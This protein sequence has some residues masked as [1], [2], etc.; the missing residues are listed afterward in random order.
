VEVGHREQCAAR[1]PRRDSWHPPSCCAE[2]VGWGELRLASAFF[3]AH[4]T[5]KHP[6][7]LK[8][9][10]PIR[11]R[12]LSPMYAVFWGVARDALLFALRRSRRYNPRHGVKYWQKELREA[13]AELDA[14]TTLTAVRAAA[15]RLQRAKAELKALE[16]ETKEQAKRRATRGE[17]G[18]SIPC[19][20]P[21]K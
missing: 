15:K 3:R 5:V 19:K 9:E 20:P 1:S 2:A 8:A 14:A 4:E 13:E 7:Q 10:P 6:L 16:A 12:R 11:T 21:Q 17:A 18:R